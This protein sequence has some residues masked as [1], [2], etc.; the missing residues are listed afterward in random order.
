MY[1]EGVYLLL[2]PLPLLIPKSVHYLINKF[3]YLTVMHSM[4]FDH[5][6]H[7]IKKKP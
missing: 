4:S 2:L 1:K 3:E 7:E 6:H 5:H